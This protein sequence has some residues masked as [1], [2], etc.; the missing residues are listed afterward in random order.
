MEG[1]PD[2]RIHKFELGSF[3]CNEKRFVV[4]LRQGVTRSACIEEFRG[5]L[6]CWESHD[7]LDSKAADY[8]RANATH[9]VADGGLNHFVWND[10]VKVKE[11]WKK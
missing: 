4:N 1:Q 8:V 5:K 11:T 9:G 10:D 7:W 6:R 2:E 3:T